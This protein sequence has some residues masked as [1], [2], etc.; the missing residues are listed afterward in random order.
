MVNLIIVKT[1][2]MRIVSLR[3]I[4]VKELQRNDL[5]S[6]KNTERILRSILCAC[7]TLLLTL[8]TVERL[9]EFEKKV[10]RTAITNPMKR[11]Q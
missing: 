4:K 8:S 2:P 3:F 9:R 7:E 10:V 11:I 1:T 6:N 5:K